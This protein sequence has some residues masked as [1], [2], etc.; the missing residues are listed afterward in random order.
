[1][2]KESTIQKEVGEIKVE[3]ASPEDVEGIINVQDET[4]I[5]TY[6]N[7]E[8]GITRAD[9]ISHV[10]SRRDKA[11]ENWRKRIE[12]KEGVRRIWV[13]KNETGG[14]VGFCLATKNET[15]NQIQAIYVL[16]NIHGGGIGKRLINEAINWLGS[17][18]PVS[19]SVAKYNT[20]AIGFY[21][22]VGFQEVEDA[23][24]VENVVFPSGRSIPEIKMVRL[25]TE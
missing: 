11:R 12:E 24:I 23:P 22:K 7:E 6:P 21:K 4:W 10:E 14:I 8:L 16:P 15:E 17:D 25:P 19:V 13:A 2:D 18:K 5:A 3:I 1:M 9:V 20:N